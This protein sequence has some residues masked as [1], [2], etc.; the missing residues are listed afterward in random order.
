MESKFCLG[1][2]GRCLAFQPWMAISELYHRKLKQMLFERE[3]IHLQTSIAGNSTLSPVCRLQTLSQKKP[4]DG[5]LY[6]MR[7]FN[8]SHSLLVRRGYKFS[9]NPL[10]T[11]KEYKCSNAV[12]FPLSTRKSNSF[13][14]SFDEELTEQKK[15]SFPKNSLGLINLLAGKLCG[16][17]KISIKQ[18]WI[19]FENLR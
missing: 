15:K 8:H 9:L 18:E 13:L 16:L 1:I 17:N 4:L 19:F 3:N 5:V 14:S 7:H 2:I 11:S 10:L 6:H 12:H